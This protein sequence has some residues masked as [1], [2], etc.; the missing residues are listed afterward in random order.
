[1]KTKEKEDEIN[2]NQKKMK[3]LEK[4]YTT[5]KTKEKE[6]EIEIRRLKNE[7]RLLRQ[8]VDQL[9]AESN[10]L[11]DRLLQGQVDRAELEENT[12]VMKRELAALRQHDL[13]TNTRLEEATHKIVK[14]ELQME[15]QS[16]G[17][18]N[19]GQK[20]D[21]IK[22]LQSELVKIELKEAENEDTIK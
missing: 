7:N 10:A 9:E 2:I 6:D 17:S 14:L 11:A 21:M 20:E 19:D 8:K 18:S 16:T 15:T 13:D 22:C 5:M 1:M 3:K 4:E 12:F